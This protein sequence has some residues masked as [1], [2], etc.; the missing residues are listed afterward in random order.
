MKTKWQP[1]F[2]VMINVYLDKDNHV[3]DCFDQYDV[4]ATLAQLLVV[5]EADLK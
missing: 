4:R 1:I 2:I 3:P 5:W